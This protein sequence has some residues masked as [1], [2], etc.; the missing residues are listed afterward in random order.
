MAQ[1]NPLIEDYRIRAIV[2]I[3]IAFVMFTASMV[4]RLVF[5]TPYR[6]MV[7]ALLWFTIVV[8]VV[9]VG[10]GVYYTQRYRHVAMAEQRLRG[11]K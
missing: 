1:K 3:V 10:L 5:D 6:P 4:I 7:L 8:Q 2:F 9:T 11:L